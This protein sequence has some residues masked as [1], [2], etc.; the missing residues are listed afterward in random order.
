[1][2]ILCKENYYS[3]YRFA[4]IRANKKLIFKKGNCYNAKKYSQ[5]HY[6]NTFRL[7]FIIVDSDFF[8]VGYHDYKP[9]TPKGVSHECS[10]FKD[11]FYDNNETRK[12][13][14]IELQNADR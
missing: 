1:M 2:N 8:Y 12:R 14:L 11:F 4:N 5:W 9:G 10:N 3:T 7:D 6:D 13:K